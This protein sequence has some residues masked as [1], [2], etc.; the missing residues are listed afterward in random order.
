[1]GKKKHEFIKEDPEI[2][3][4][5]TGKAF[6]ISSLLTIIVITMGCLL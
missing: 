5:V 4:R 2:M 6:W 1:M 3:I